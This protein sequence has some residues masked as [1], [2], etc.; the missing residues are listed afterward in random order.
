[1]LRSNE[2]LLHQMEQQLLL[3]QQQAKVGKHHNIAPG[4]A[5]A[6]AA[7][8]T[9]PVTCGSCCQQDHLDISVS[10]YQVHPALLGQL[11]CLGKPQCVSSRPYS[12]S[13]P[14]GPKVIH[15]KLHVQEE[16]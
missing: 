13:S 4:A 3:C 6:A 11:S 9:S 5:S 7:A 12:P 15:L 10:G 2:Q 8:R 14:Q 1:V 16:Q